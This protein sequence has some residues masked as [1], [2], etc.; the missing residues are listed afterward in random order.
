MLAVAATS[1][2]MDLRSVARLAGV[3]HTR[4]VLSKDAPKRVFNPPPVRVQAR[5]APAEAIKLA[6]RIVDKVRTAEEFKGVPSYV[7]P[8]RQQGPFTWSLETIRSARDLQIRGDF[9]LP[10]RLAEAMRTD[11]ALYVAYHNRIAPQS[12]CGTKLV[13]HDSTRGANVARK[14]ANSVRIPRSVLE[15]IAGTM[16]NHGIAIGYIEQ[17]TNDEGTQVDFRL[18]EWP[19]EHVKWDLSRSELWT[20]TKDLSRVPITHGDGRWVIFR[21]FI[22][23]PWTQ[24]ACVLPG[25]FIWAA[26]ANGIKDWALASTSHGQAKIVGTLPEGL[27]LQDDGGKLTPEA[28]GFLA[29]MQDLISG[30]G[31][32]GISPFGSVVNFLANGSTAWQVFSELIL[33]RE[34]AAARIYLGTDA[35]MG[36]AGGAPGVDIA[37][38]FGVAS[39]KIQGDFSAIE[40]AL[41]TGVYEPWTAIN[42]GDSRYAPSLKYELPD[43]DAAAK[44]AE[45]AAKLS[46]LLDALERY[47]KL[48][49]VL[50]Q[51]VV[52]ALA[53][54]LGVDCPP[55]VGSTAATQLQ[56]PDVAI[57][58]LVL[59]REG[60]VSQGLAPFA[61]ERDNMTLDEIAIYAKGRADAAVAKAKAAATGEANVAVAQVKADPTTAPPVAA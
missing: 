6:S 21:K 48:N 31:G 28:A 17:E 55:Q 57:T 12:A 24:E 37:K 30:E 54:L 44:A 2:I 19:L 52:N 23:L 53:L 25:A 22:E 3:K 33:N 10:V 40:Q 16:A 56:L 34:K 45:R 36:A 7:A 11:D 46:G 1:W 26:H 58:A 43:P 59:G 41:K 18:T 50:T 39:T 14:A 5:R 35:M 61:D 51:E 15:G 29:M 27:S 20:R 4:R 13:A 8:I 38:L 60:R 32:A 47:R 49:L 42:E 9:Y